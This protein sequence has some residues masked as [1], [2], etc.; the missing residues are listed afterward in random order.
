MKE[1]EK[2][3][4]AANLG[5]TPQN[6]GEQLRIVLPK[7]TEER[8]KQ[9]VKDVKKLSEDAKVAIR[10]IRRDINDG[11]KKAQKTSEITEDEEKIYLDDVQKLTDQY[12]EN[13]EKELALKEKD[14]ME[15]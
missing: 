13:I 14:L 4:L 5:V 12:I 3:I 6:E 11:I 10:N 1:A 2:A 7:L 9:L 15:I 8:R